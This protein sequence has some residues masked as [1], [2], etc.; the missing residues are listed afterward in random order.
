MTFQSILALVL[1][2]LVMSGTPGPNNLILAS[3]G[4]AFGFRRTLPALLG[5]QLGLVSLLIVCGSGI[6][7]AVAESSLLQSLLKVLGTSYL[8]YLAWKLWRVSG[9]SD[10][11]ASEPLTLWQAA[12]FQFLN[13]KAWMMAVSAVS[14]FAV[15]AEHYS[16]ALLS[17]A[18][19]FLF[20]STPIIA[21]WAAFGAAM[22]IALQEQGRT[23]VFN[24]GMAILTAMSALMIV[25]WS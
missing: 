13:P 14:A 10:V 21:I 25:F 11:E 5:I 6:G 15:P 24:R 9:V 17:V 3:S 1:F 23:V 2:S 8:L 19:V 22:K 16:P 7:S 18:T 12:A 4:L 20:I